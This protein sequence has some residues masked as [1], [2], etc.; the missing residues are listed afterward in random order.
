MEKSIQILTFSTMISWMVATSLLKWGQ[1]HLQSGELI[2]HRGLINLVRLWHLE[3]QFIKSTTLVTEGAMLSGARLFSSDVNG[4]ESQRPPL[5][6][7]HFTSDAVEA[8]VKQINASLK[9]KEFAWLFENCFPNTLN[10]R[11]DFL[12]KMTGRIPI[13]SPVI[14]VLC[15]FATARRKCDLICLWCERIKSCSN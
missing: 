11:V 15:D 8:L 14:M 9:N 4:F 6:K 13:S 7:W 12:F 5:A 10:M 1:C 2:L 3:K